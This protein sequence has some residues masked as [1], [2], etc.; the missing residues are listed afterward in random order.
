MNAHREGAWEQRWHP[1]R[2]EW[3]IVAA[4]RQERPWT[5]G[6]VPA[7]PQSVPAYD[8]HC[9]LC[10]GNARVQGRRNPDYAQTFVFDNDGPCVALDAPRDLPSA[11]P[12]YQ[13]APALGVSRVVCFSP[14]HDLTLAE[15][16]RAEI[17][18]VLDVWRREYIDLGALPEVNHVLVFEN[19]GEIVGVSNP[20][21]HGQIYATNFI[22][23]IMEIEVEA[24]RRHARETGRVLFADILE[25]ELREKRR[26][27]CEQGSAAAFVPWFGRYAYET[28]VAPIRTHPHIAALSDREVQDLAE[29]LRRTLVMMDNLWRMSFPYIMSLHQAPTDGGA[30]PDFHFHI[31]LHPP[32]R[33]PN[34]M[35]YLGGAEAGGGNFLSDTVPEEKAAELRQADGPHYRTLI[36]GRT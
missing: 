25:T 35:K 9:Y 20:H 13:R 8:P 31:E 21:P 2:Q 19:K 32:L 36:Q 16:S 24:C 23:R 6:T 22:S 28:F 18:T 34:L 27:V 14:R 4:H 33:K 29:A 12:G 1:L 15:M 17:E 7:A 10:P 30:Y 11:P 5:G 3:V 26:I